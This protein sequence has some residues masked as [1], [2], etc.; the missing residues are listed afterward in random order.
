MAKFNTDYLLLRSRVLTLYGRWRVALA[1]LDA[2]AATHPDSPYQ[3][4]VDFYR[5]RALNE[6]GQKDEARKIWADLVKTYPLSELAAPAREALSK[7]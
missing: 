1:E 7:P 3:I 5:A 4:D 6:L 2:F